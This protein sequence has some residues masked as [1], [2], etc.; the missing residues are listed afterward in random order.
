[1]DEPWAYQTGCVIQAPQFTNLHA[2]WALVT[3]FGKSCC[4][5]GGGLI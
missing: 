4:F 5:S 1:M 3:W 2:A